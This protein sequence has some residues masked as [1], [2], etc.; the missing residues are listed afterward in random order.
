MKEGL[1]VDRAAEHGDDLV[2]ENQI[3]GGED[4]A[5]RYAE[6]DRIADASA[7]LLSLLPPETDRDERAAAVSHHDRDGERHDRQR[8]DDRIGRVAVG[9]QIA[10]VR[11]K[12]LV[13]DVIKRADK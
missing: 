13:D 6:K 11:D 4:Q 12:D 9:A 1:L 10:G 7:R 3:D 8:E 5:G 2:S